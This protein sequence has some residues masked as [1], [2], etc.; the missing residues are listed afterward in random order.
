MSTPVQPDPG[1]WPVAYFEEPP[2]D[3]APPTSQPF[4]TWRMPDGTDWAYFFRGSGG[5]LVRFPRLADFEVSPDG[6]Q[7]RAW[8]TPGATHA[9]VQ[10]LYLN[11]VLP[12]ALSKQGRIVLHASAVDIAGQ[13]VAFMGPSGRG[14]STLA[15]SFATHGSGF[16][17]DDGLHLEWHDNELVVAPSHP[18]IRLWDDSRNALG[19]DALEV[20][21]AAAY[22]SK[23]RYLAGPGLAF[24]AE[25]RPLRRVYLLGADAAEG[26]RIRRAQPAQ[27][28]MA[29]VRNSF[30][31][32]IEEHAMLARHFDDFAR[33][34]E[35]P[36]HYH[37]DYPRHYDELPRLRE[38]I[39]RHLLETDNE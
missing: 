17:T 11:Q 38:A 23:A 34:S 12:L 1:G 15:A 13:A 32:D 5:Y 33:I 21:P 26:P 4:H 3:Q 7:V 27:A 10:Q 18:S 2:R 14:K 30:L 37:L 6:R 22:T 28:L 20:A 24:C 25:A 8:P 36:I 35:K 9:T 29:M 31:L 39:S 19:A 16:L